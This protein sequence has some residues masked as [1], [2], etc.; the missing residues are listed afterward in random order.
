M[1]TQKLLRVLQL[2]VDHTNWAT[3]PHDREEV[4]GLLSEIRHSEVFFDYNEVESNPVESNPNN[5]YQ[6]S[7]PPAQSALI[8][9]WRAWALKN[10]LRTEQ[11]VENMTKADLQA[12]IAPA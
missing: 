9:E 2:L 5:E 7:H 12:L 11:E 10:R 3:C 4:D 1:D 8:A 6:L